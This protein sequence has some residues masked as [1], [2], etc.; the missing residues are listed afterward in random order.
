M[1]VADHPGMFLV[2]HVLDGTTYNDWK[3]AMTIALESKNMDHC[4]DLL[5][6]IR[7]T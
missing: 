5:N 3:F 4:L 6:L 1:H 2:L 7:S